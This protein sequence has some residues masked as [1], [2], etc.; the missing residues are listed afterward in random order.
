[1]I[2]KYYASHLKNSL[3]AASINIMRPR[4]IKKN[5]PPAEQEG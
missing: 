3:D 1:M 2:E 5:E 4:K